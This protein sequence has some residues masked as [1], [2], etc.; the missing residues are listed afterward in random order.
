M[1][2][3]GNKE[4]IKDPFGAKRSL[5]TTKVTMF[6]TG[7]IDQFRNFLIL[8]ETSGRLVDVSDL[9]ISTGD[10]LVRYRVTLKA[11]SYDVA[12]TSE[13]VPAAVPVE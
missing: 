10:G 9:D 12:A 3:A 13:E 5:Q 2:S 4:L 11:Y 1:I 6:V 8:L 7:T